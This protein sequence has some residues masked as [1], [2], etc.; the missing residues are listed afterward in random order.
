MT[1]W[2]GVVLIPETQ[3]ELE[4]LEAMPGEA[5]WAYEQGTAKIEASYKRYEADL[6]LSV[7]LVIYR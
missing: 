7:A 2:W 5:S 4:V 3:R 6:P 1:E